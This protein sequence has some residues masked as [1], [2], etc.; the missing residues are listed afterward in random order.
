VSAHSNNDTLDDGNKLNIST[1]LSALPS[2]TIPVVKDCVLEMTETEISLIVDLF[3]S[4]RV[5]VLDI[6]VSFSGTSNEKHFLSDFHV[7]LINPIGQ[8]ILYTLDRWLFRY[9][10]WTLN[11]GIR[12]IKL[13]FKE[14]RNYCIKREKKL[15]HFAFENTQNIIRSINLA[16]NYEVCSSYKETS[17]GEVKRTCCHVTKS[18]SMK[19]DY[20]CSK[21]ASFLY[22]SSVPRIVVTFLMNVF[23]NFYLMWLLYVL[24][25]RTKFDL[26]YPK[27]YK[28]EESRISLSF[29]L[30]KI[31]WEENGRV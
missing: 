31:I 13:H 30:L 28:L 5:N 25:S 19:S 6:H 21:L 1:T 24:L 16:T 9:V 3:N 15:H 12:N 11:A 7:V 10:T 23:V 29:I 20:G 26:K 2:T 18:N 4:N 8:E 22:A 14:N 27:Y 17:S